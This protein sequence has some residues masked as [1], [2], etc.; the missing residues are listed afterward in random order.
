MSICS[1]LFILFRKE[2]YFIT[3]RTATFICHR[4]NS[5]LACWC[6]TCSNR[7]TPLW[8]FFLLWQTHDYSA[9][10][11]RVPC[12]TESIPHT[13]APSCP[14][15]A[16]FSDWSVVYAGCQ[17]PYP[18][19]HHSERA[20]LPGVSQENLAGELFSPCCPLVP[21]AISSQFS[22]YESLWKEKWWYPSNCPGV[23][24]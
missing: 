1:I 6:R 10:H 18:R 12:L 17:T 14:L 3:A 16:R 4:K 8:V 21:H 13:A 7:P 20:E 2:V 24:A 5:D 15:S 22:C 23:S 11:Q 19:L 9:I